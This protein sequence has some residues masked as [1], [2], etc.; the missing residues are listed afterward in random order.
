M[1]LSPIDL[2]VVFVYF[3]LLFGFGV[4]VRRIRGFTD[5]S[6]AN[7]QVP[8]SMIFASI[9]ATYIGPGFSVGIV[10]KAYSSGY[11]FFILPLF[12]VFQTIFVGAF[13]AKRIHGFNNSHSVGDIIGERYGTLSQF[14]AG[15]VSVGLSIGFAAIMAKVGGGMLAQATGLPLIASIAIVTG[16]GVIYTYTGGLKSVIATEA[17]QF[18][19]FS[20]AFPVVLLICVALPSFPFNDAGDRSLALTTSALT[21]MSPMQLFGI[22]VSFLLGEMLIPPYTNRI[23][24]SKDKNIASHGFLMAGMFGIVWLG[25]VVSLGLVGSILL[26]A[27]TPEDEVF[28]RLVVSYAPHGLIGLVVVALIAIVMS[29]Q[30]SVLNAG[31]VSFTRDIIDKVLTLKDQHALWLTKGFTLL[32]GVAATV[33]AISAPSIID[34]LLIMYSIWAPTVLVPLIAGLF[35]KKTA[36]AAGYLSMLVGGGSSLAWRLAFGEPFGVPS[37]LVGLGAS[38]IVYSIAHFIFAPR[39][40]PEPLT[41][42]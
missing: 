29:S 24:A 31:A 42:V 41:G 19:V 38:V 5:Y 17:F 21:A 10:G 8:V 18:S 11:V 35:L 6:V 13:L 23:L 34:G 25:I 1:Q 26:P 22:A 20:I 16:T 28:A 27:G 15:I 32:S 4:L 40:Q 9:A 7:R 14:I 33:F 36:N 30:E 39:K 12:F 3:L 37:I 2:L